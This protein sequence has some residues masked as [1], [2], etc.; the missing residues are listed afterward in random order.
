MLHGKFTVQFPFYSIA[1]TRTSVKPRKACFN[2][3]L[4]SVVLLS[5]SLI[6]FFTGPWASY[7]NSQIP[8][9]EKYLRFLGQSF[10]TA[11]DKGR[12][13]PITPS[14]NILVTPVNGP[15]SHK[16]FWRLV[17]CLKGSWLLQH[18]LSEPIIPLSTGGKRNPQ[19]Q[20]QKPH[21]K[22]NPREY[23]REL[24]NFD[25]NPKCFLKAHKT[26]RMR[27]TVR[28]SRLQ[29]LPPSSGFSLVELGFLGRTSP[30]SVHS[31]P[32][33]DRTLG[34]PFS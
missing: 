13:L 17:Y 10:A 16:V 27:Q 8:D 3:I 12:N 11:C 2:H 20:W 1:S 6:I 4:I 15:Q 5:F 23:S 33:L 19:L 28:S 31:I 9:R 14:L 21:L 32:A 34:P 30:C 22:K 7:S 18:L 25:E 26:R 29:A 24:S